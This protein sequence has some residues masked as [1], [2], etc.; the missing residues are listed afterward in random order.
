MALYIL[1]DPGLSVQL[2]AKTRTEIGALRALNRH[3]I[4]TRPVGLADIDTLAEDPQA[5]LL[6]P[7]LHA[8]PETVIRRCEQQAIPVI[9]LHTP[10]SSFPALHFS[11]VCGHAHSDADALLRYCAAAGR[12][13]LALFA[14]NSVSAVDRSRAQ[15]IADRAATLQPEDLFAA[16]D[17]FETSFARFYPHRQQYDA[18]HFANDYAAIAFIEAMQAADPA[19]LAGHFLI[20]AADTLLS[21]LYHTTVTTIAYRRRDLL[22]GVATV[23]RTL[24]RDRGSVVSLQYQLPAAIA[25]RQSTQHFPLPPEAAPLPGSGSSTRLRFPEQGFFYEQDPVLGRIMATEDQLCAM[26]RTE[27]QI[28]LHFLQGDT[29]RHTAEALYISDQALLYHTRRMF[30]RAGVADKQT[31]IRFFARYVS[32]AHL[33]AYLHTHACAG[34]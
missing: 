18:I 10:G 1:D 13:R 21:R 33:A 6:L 5:V 11:S 30:R 19:Y 32:P 34:T 23:Y 27:L 14:F 29:N 3:R 31:F 25:V 26:D 17:S 15:A 7:Q 9:V 20:G 16:V 8:A 28:L 22:R 2:P 12:Q 4:P 24:L